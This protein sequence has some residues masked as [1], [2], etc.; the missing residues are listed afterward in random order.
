MGHLR[1]LRNRVIIIAIALVIGAAVGWFLYD[2]VLHLLKA[3]IDEVAHSQGRTAELNYAGIASPFDI[4]IK[5][6][7][8]IGVFLT[9]PIWLYQVWAFI[10]PGL[11]KKEKRYSLGFLL[12]A[13][14]LFLA[15]ACCAFFALPNAVKALGSMIPSGASY[16]VPAQDY[17]TF[18][19]ILIIVFGIAF[20]LPV[21]LVG[22]NMLGILS[23]RSLR[24][25]WRWI[26][27]LIFAFAAVATP[28]PDAV[29]MFYLVVPMTVMF[30]LAWVLC[31]LGDRRRKR[32]MI[33]EG[34][35]V[36]PADED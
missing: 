20:V 11:T 31:A 15:G 35:W 9:S 16:I 2:P 23:A 24:N 6:S 34:T 32:R 1:E 5:V 3:P 28:S 25:S 14:P 22:L 33:A 18:V 29:S 26:V 13:L 17:L 7:V 30:V 4:Q 8:F 27:V 12:S 10:V 36:E 19:M 21:L